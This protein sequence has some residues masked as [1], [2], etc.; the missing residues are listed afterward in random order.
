ME[1]KLLETALKHFDQAAK[2]LKLDDS[3]CEVLKSC[4]RELTVSIPVIMDD[5]KTK[6][7][8][9]YRVQHSSL[10][11][12]CKGGIRYHPD[13]SL[14]EVK[15]LASLMTW[16]CAVVGIPY[17]GAKGG[18]KVDPHKLSLRELEHLTRRFTVGIMPLIGAK[19]DIPAPDVNTNAK[20]MSWIMDT[21]SMFERNSVTE[22]VTGKSV[23]LGGS[24][25]RHEST[26]R[27]VMIT[28]LA[29]LKKLKKDVK[30]TTFAVQGFGNVGSIA[31]KLLDAQGAKIVAISDVSGGLYNPKGLNLKA[32]FEHLKKSKDHLLKGFKG[33]ASTIS[34]EDLL[35]LPVDVL[36]PA[37]L[38]DQITVKNAAKIKAKLIV[39]GANGPVTYEADKILEKQKIMVVPDILANSGGVTVSYFEWVQDLQCFF[40]SEAE[41]NKHLQNILEAAFENVW[42][43]SQ[44]E[45]VSLR[46]AAFILAIKKVAYALEQ[47]G[48][49]P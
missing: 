28:A 20:V 21:V 32:V 30:K 27:G 40:W 41:V 33:E 1:N 10:R 12:P 17:G 6:V 42:E 49:F 7:F 13:V 8:T 34:N 19:R 22:I 23:E 16:K 2:H 48:I 18:I 24:L 4:E 5:G 47:R 36:I 31:A 39:E 14:E 37:A 29:A 15:G 11:G 46:I 45:K 44:Q 43:I 35:L 9:G 3:T 25:G 26:G 38:E